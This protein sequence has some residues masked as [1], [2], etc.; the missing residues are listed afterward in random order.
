MMLRNRIL[1]HASRTMMMRPP[2]PV[3]RTTRT[4]SSFQMRSTATEYVMQD[5]DFFQ[6]VSYLFLKN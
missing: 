4:S 5:G 6:H 2:A 1:L 3:N